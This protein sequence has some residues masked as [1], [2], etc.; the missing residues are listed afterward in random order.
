ML[1]LIY[2]KHVC[3]SYVEYHDVFSGQRIEGNDRTLPCSPK[4]GWSGIT[5]PRKT[6]TNAIALAFKFCYV[7]RHNAAA[8]TNP[9]N[10]Q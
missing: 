5:Q 3:G 7:R 1:L 2:I 10:N 6:C 8:S 4:R 9:I